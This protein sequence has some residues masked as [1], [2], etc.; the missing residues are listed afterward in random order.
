M[1]RIAEL[2]RKL[3]E[4]QAAAKEARDESSTPS[5]GSS[6]GSVNA[7]A[8][9]LAAN[10]NPLMF[11]PGAKPPPILRKQQHDDGKE[12]TANGEDRKEDGGT[13]NATSSSGGAIT[14]ANRA[15]SSSKRRPRTV[16]PAFES[17]VSRKESDFELDMSSPPSPSSTS[18]SVSTSRAMG[19]TV[20]DLD[21]SHPPL[22]PPSGNGTPEKE[23]ATLDLLTPPTGA[24]KSVSMSRT[25][26]EQFAMLDNPLDD[27]EGMSLPDSSAPPAIA[28][29]DL[30]ATQSTPFDEDMIDAPSATNAPSAVTSTNDAPFEESIHDNA[31][32]AE[33]QEMEDDIELLLADSQ[34]TTNPQPVPP[35]SQPPAATSSS[36]V[37]PTAADAI[38]P[39]VDVDRRKHS[40]SLSFSDSLAL[41]D[42]HHDENVA[43]DDYTGDDNMDGESSV[44]SNSLD[45]GEDSTFGTPK[46]NFASPKKATVATAPIPAET[47]YDRA[48]SPS[49]MEA[50]ST[51]V[52]SDTVNL[53][54]LTAA[55]IADSAA[56]SSA[57]AVTA[58]DAEMDQLL[59]GDHGFDAFDTATSLDLSVGDI[60]ARADTATSPSK[61]STVTAKEESSH[62]M[63]FSVQKSP[64]ATSSIS[65]NQTATVYL[66]S[67]NHAVETSTV[68]D[69]SRLEEENAA[70]D[71]DVDVD[72]EATRFER[73]QKRQDI[74]AQLARL[75]QLSGDESPLDARESLAHDDLSASDS[76]AD[77]PA[78]EVPPLDPAHPTM[79]W[80]ELAAARAKA[81]LKPPTPSHAK[82]ASTGA[83]LVAEREKHEAAKREA[84]LEYAR[85]LAPVVD[86]APERATGETESSKHA[87]AE[88]EAQR[89]ELERQRSK[90]EAY[91]TQRFDAN[92]EFIPTVP[93]PFGHVAE[94]TSSAVAKQRRPGDGESWSGDES[95]V[96]LLR[97][98][99][100]GAPPPSDENGRALFVDAQ[101]RPISTK[102]VEREEL[103]LELLK[104]QASNKPKRSGIPT[105]T[106]SG[107]PH[108]ATPTKAATAA[109]SAVASSPT[110]N[111]SASG[112]KKP[113]ALQP[114]TS[115]TKSSSSSKKKKK[116]KLVEPMSITSPR[117]LSASPS[118][119]SAIPSPSPHA[120][121]S[122]SKKKRG[123]TAAEEAASLHQLARPTSAATSR[124]AQTSK[125]TSASGAATAR[126]AATTPSHEKTSTSTKKSSS[127]K[128]SAS[129]KKSARKSGIPVTSA[130]KTPT[131][132]TSSAPSKPSASPSS[133]TSSLKKKKTATTSATTT[134]AP[135]SKT[136][137]SSSS[138]PTSSPLA[139]ARTKTTRPSTATAS[140]S[141]SSSSSGTSATAATGSGIKK[142]STTPRPATAQPKAK[143][144][145]STTPTA[146]VA[147]SS[148]SSASKTP[149]ARPASAK[150]ASATGSSSSHK[151]KKTGIPSPTIAASSSIP[152]PASTS[153]LPLASPSTPKRPLSAKKKKIPIL[154][155]TT[156][157]LPSPSPSKSKLAP[158]RPVSARSGIPSASASS[159]TSSSIPT[160]S[161]SGIPSAS[162]SL[163]TP[164]KLS[165][166]ISLSSLPSPQPLIFTSKKQKAKDTT[167]TVS[168]SSPLAPVTPSSSAAPASAPVE[169][170]IESSPVSPPIPTPTS[171]PT[172][173]IAPVAA[174]ST[175]TSA[176]T[177]VADP[178]TTSE[179]GD[180]GL[181]AGRDRAATELAPPCCSSSST[182]SSSVMSTQSKFKLAPYMDAA[183][184]SNVLNALPS[185]D[186]LPPSSRPVSS[187][188][189]L[190]S[191]V[192]LSGHHSRSKSASSLLRQKWSHEKLLMEM[193]EVFDWLSRVVD[194]SNIVLSHPLDP[195][196]M[197]AT[198]EN[199]GVLCGLIAKCQQLA[200][201]KGDPSLGGKPIAFKKE[202]RVGS[203]VARDN[204]ANFLDAVQKWGLPRS[205]LFEVDDLVLRKNGTAPKQNRNDT[206]GASEKDV[207]TL[208]ML[209]CLFV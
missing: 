118:S 105:M 54:D 20:D 145:T 201:A 98:L 39:D 194:G 107:I 42:D 184:M 138:K 117:G 187:S 2:Q 15:K 132:S 62:G 135:T 195:D 97:N 199:G 68:S 3:A 176:T 134:T 163:L 86:A 197:F 19:V 99:E 119:S 152:S 28:T 151:K 193:A 31:A 139:T 24:R 65:T 13:T 8:R 167:G 156:N 122:S 77:A 76:M 190:P 158:P 181:S 203:F 87:R 204:L 159:S 36:P 85:T 30:A 84:R 9:S 46:S 155:V 4:Q 49:G 113:S 146:S 45:L 188:A 27:I 206:Q 125:P 169:V 170:S 6:G 130:S 66:D 131:S 32:T 183:G 186:S 126:T 16:R 93:K 128:K 177:S 161:P 208:L 133:S 207:L 196:A 61:K 74:K 96:A 103:E 83:R 200:L 94:P 147:S 1:S 78:V 79:S 205:Q 22:P 209:N 95:Q 52:V 178:A 11:Q 75:K 153:S 102:L 109:P 198:I 70:D 182:S 144:A 174:S 34:T 43:D 185:P 160:S 189:A 37:K 137:T 173:P 129:V 82:T 171:A 121:S 25:I 140:S 89:A 47:L 110:P 149:T 33:D 124:I 136:Q 104:L 40:F 5:I 53:T 44:A 67:A 91:Y 157:V 108:Y 112:L 41:D 63:H 148:S 180:V 60:D 116:Q 90:D 92:G 10:F 26:D 166:S 38:D 172:Q 115:V 191:T 165:G 123:L 35:P 48:P 150:A 88:L 154:T 57:S 18:I 143:K 111:S 51:S 69:D 73:E 80:H 23:T 71:I 106:P 192:K 14:H 164:K 81:A 64:T 141:S 72:D 120:K 100:F 55:P 202:A 168:V 50:E 7:A 101:K 59:G 21:P 12:D 162:S 175:T 17:S 56:A 179:D 127:A 58:F 29:S 142:P 114:P